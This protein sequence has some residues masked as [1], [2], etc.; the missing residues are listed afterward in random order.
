MPRYYFDI[1]SDDVA[2]DNHGVEMPDAAAARL[3]AIS[4]LPEIAADEIPKDGDRQ[5]YAV[6]VRDEQGHTIYTATL[7]FS[8]LWTQT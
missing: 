2:R 3:E 7:T 4:A 8:G 5:L 6:V 1:H